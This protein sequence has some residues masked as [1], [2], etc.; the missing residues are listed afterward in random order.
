MAASSDRRRRPLTLPAVSGAVLRHWR[1]ERRT[2]RQGLV[3]LA[4]CVGVTVIAGVVLGAME[5]LLERLPGL[6]V[7]VPAAIGMRG[8]VFGAMG[9]RLGTG[10]LTGQYEAGWAPTS[11]LRQNVEASLLL[12]AIMSGFLAVAARASAGAFGLET[13]SIWALLMVSMLGAA[14]SSV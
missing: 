14:L 9:A 2:L 13:I 11:F 5:G 8:A 1:R 7:L 6:L 10:I 4:V 3:A 12:T